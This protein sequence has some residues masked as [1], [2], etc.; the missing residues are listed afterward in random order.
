MKLSI[1]LSA[2]IA[3]AIS[4]VSASAYS[5]EFPTRPIV[6]VVPFAAGSTSDGSARI[7]ALQMSKSLG[8]PITVENRVGAGGTIG[9]AFVA[10][11][12]PDG[13][14]LLWAPSS[15]LAIA[16]HVMSKLPWDPVTRKSSIAS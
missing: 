11:S 16:P 1:I 5:A 9:A 14:T 3:S 10:R 8:Q 2:F 6:L 15:V 7:A 4:L 13:Y 12:A